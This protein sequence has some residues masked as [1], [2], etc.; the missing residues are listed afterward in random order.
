MTPTAEDR[1]RKTFHELTMTL[2]GLFEVYDVDP[3]FVDHAAV[4]I[5]AILRRGLEV[6]PQGRGARGTRG[7][8]ALERLLDELEAAGALH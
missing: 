4:E 3:E 7:K 2:V 5:E 1:I 6:C 8:L